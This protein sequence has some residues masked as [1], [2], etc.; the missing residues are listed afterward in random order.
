MKAHGI[1]CAPRLLSF[2][3]I[4]NLAA[5]ELPTSA[6]QE[7]A[8]RRQGSGMQIRCRAGF[9]TVVIATVIATEMIVGLAFGSPLLA[10]QRG[11]DPREQIGEVLGKP[12]YRDQIQSGKDD[13]LASELHRLFTEPVMQKYQ[14]EH[15]AEITPTE[16][17]ISAAA[18]YFD[19]RLQKQWKEWS[20][21]ADIEGILGIITHHPRLDATD[22]SRRM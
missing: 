17:D 21:S 3:L 11:G 14:Q 8:S 4:G 22:V 1:T 13:S 20:R 5:V 7:T 15:R 6:N 12:V 9:C 18:A 2:S 10:E 16:A 19:A